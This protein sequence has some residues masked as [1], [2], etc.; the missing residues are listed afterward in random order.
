MKN[1]DQDFQSTLDNLLKSRKHIKVLEAGCGSI[2][3]VTFKP[4]TT[5]TG[6]DISEKQLERNKM[7]VEKILGDIQAYDFPKEAYDVIVCTYVL[8]HLPRPKRALENFSKAVKKGGFIILT[9]PNLFSLKGFITK[10][11]PLWFHVFVYKHIYGWE[12][13]GHADVGPFKNYMRLSMSPQFLIY[14]A[15]KN[16][17]EIVYVE[18]ADALDSWVRDKLKKK[19]KWLFWM[20]KFWVI[21]FRIISFGKIRESEFITIFQKKM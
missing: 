3:K 6:I 7:L 9:V 21:F 14:F 1:S 12:N 2:S 8:E 5:I 10:F 11:S 4:E 19:G 20:V 16:N 18:F 13:P 15:K 17:F